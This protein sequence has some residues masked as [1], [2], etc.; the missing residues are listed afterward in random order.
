MQIFFLM[1]EINVHKYFLTLPMSYN[2]SYIKCIKFIY[3]CND[4]YGT[5]VVDDYRKSLKT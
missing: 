1:I 5:K 4:Y 3:T 2:N